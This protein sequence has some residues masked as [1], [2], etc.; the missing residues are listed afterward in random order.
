MRNAMSLSHTDVARAFKHL[1]QR[2]TDNWDL[3]G[4]FL[5]AN[6]SLITQ[7]D[8]Q[9]AFKIACM[10]TEQ[11]SLIRILLTIGITVNFVRADDSYV[12]CETAKRGHM[13]VVQILLQHVEGIMAKDVRANAS[14]VLRYACLYNSIE[15]I[16][17]L[18]AIPDA[19]R[20]D[21]LRANRHS[22]LRQVADR[23]L[24]A[25]LE[26]LLTVDGVG[27]SDVTTCVD[28]F[29]S[30]LACAATHN[31]RT[32]VEMMLNIPTMTADYVRASRALEFLPPGY[33]MHVYLQQYIASVS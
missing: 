30:P 17:L 28:G 7:N 24:D 32:T 31:H 21:D 11:C 4:S 15:T 29:W 18:M 2:G 5:A 26:R 8:L 10:E 23:G 3:A 13:E 25:I 22:V 33:F 14:C 6:V 12:L 1:A 20:I 16:D 19:V 27:A 9:S